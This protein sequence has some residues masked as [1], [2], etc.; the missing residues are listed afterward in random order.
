MDKPKCE[1]ENW[2]GHWVKIINRNMI[3]LNNQKLYKYGFTVSQLSVMSQLWNQDGLSLK[4]LTERLQI[5]P[6]S[7][8]GLID[9][10]VEKGWLV[11]KE[12]EQDAR[13]KRI[14]LT[15]Q[16][17]N[18]KMKSLEVVNE[19]EEILCKGFTNEEK[20]V[21]ICWFKKIYKNLE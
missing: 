18:I 8:T 19:M 4:E 10:L 12:D 14:Y 3:N 11:R 20:Q 21:L 5:K 13:I 1:V 7:L 2:I 6:P 9:T 16:G 15:E 17:K